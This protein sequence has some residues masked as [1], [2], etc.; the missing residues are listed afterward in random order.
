M[1]PIFLL[2]LIELVERME[3]LAQMESAGILRMTGTSIT[4]T[5]TSAAK[6]QFRVEAVT[7]YVVV[8]AGEAI[9]F[10]TVVLLSPAGGS[11]VKVKG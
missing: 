3:S 6:E 1:I 9:G 4:S 11:Q 2:K 7:V 10:P 8:V 5:T